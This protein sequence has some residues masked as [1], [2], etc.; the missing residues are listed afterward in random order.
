MR[1]AL[2]VH[3]LC[4]A[5]WCR[6]FGAA[7]CC[8]VPSGADPGVL[9]FPALRVVVRLGALCSVRCVCAVVWY[10]GLLFAAV[11]C[12]VVVSGCVAV[13]SLPS[14][15][16]AV[17]GCAALVRLHCAV[18]VTCAVS[19]TR[20]C[21]ALLCVLLLPVV[22]CGALLGLAVRGCLLVACFGAGVPVWPRGL[23]PCG[24][25]GLLRCP[26]PLCCVLWC[27]GAV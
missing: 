3:P 9:R 12:A 2:V 23:L 27:Y 24:W 22:C 1:L 15:L 26:A 16:C 17:L 5:I 18:R 4:C 13:L 10:C 19:G 14:L 11:V 8:V 20:C 7:A 6:S 21:G 25:C